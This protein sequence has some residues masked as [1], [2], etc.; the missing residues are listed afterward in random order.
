MSSKCR[1]STLGSAKSHVSCCTPQWKFEAVTIQNE[2]V[3]KNVDTQCNSG[4]NWTIECPEYFSQISKSRRNSS[5]MKNFSL[6]EEFLSRKFFAWVMFKR[7]VEWQQTIHTSFWAFHGAPGEECLIHNTGR[8]EVQQ[9]NSL[10]SQRP[11][12]TR[13]VSCWL[14]LSLW[15]FFYPIFLTFTLFIGHDSRVLE[16]VHMLCRAVVR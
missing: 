16:A 3:Q 1:V 15:S 9:T 6:G 12:D 10:T 5:W 2:P 4:I 14:Y 13:Y 8:R 7:L 11:V